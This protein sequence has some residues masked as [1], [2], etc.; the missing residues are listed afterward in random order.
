LEWSNESPDFSDEW[1]SRFLRRLRAWGALRP[2]TYAELTKRFI[3]R[4]DALGSA[5]AE[6]CVPYR[7]LDI[8]GVTWAQ[9]GPFA[10]L[11][12]E[13]KPMNGLPS[14][15]FTSKFCHLLLPK[16]FPISDNRPGSK[17]PRYAE[18]FAFA[19]WLWTSTPESTQTELVAIMTEAVESSG[20][21]LNPEFPMIDKIVELRMIC[22]RHP[23]RLLS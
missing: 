20:A 21:K 18:Y 2:A 10:D 16:V 14:P 12:G 17:W 22:R 3:E 6:D 19:Q 23:E 7:S 8:T 9:V 11:A 4:R 1:W 15:V 5:W 13:I